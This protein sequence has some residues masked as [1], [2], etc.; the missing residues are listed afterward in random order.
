MVGEVFQKATIPARTALW[1]VG[2]MSFAT[3][4][5]A[6]NDTLLKLAAHDLSP[7]N[8]MF[9]RGISAALWS[10]PLLLFMRQAPNLRSMTNRWVLLRSVLHLGSVFCFMLAIRHLPLGD[11][12]ALGQLS[13]ALLIVGVS[14]L[15]GERIG[16]MRLVFVALA[17]FGAL[18]LAQ[19]GSG[20]ISPYV[21]LGLASAI[22]GATRDLIGQQIPPDIPVLLVV[23]TNLMFE[24]VGAGLVTTA[25][26]SWTI[27]A[28][29]G[30][31]LLAGSG[32]FLVIG[33]S[34]FFLSYRVGSIGQ[35]AP[36]YYLYPVWS[37]LSGLLVF[38]D[39]LSGTGLIGIALI[40]MSGVA[41]VLT[42]AGD[43]RQGPLPEPFPIKPD[44]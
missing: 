23:I 1:G 37:F 39:P 20:S 15:F 4:M 9:Y 7:I 27:P 26:V 6:A 12:V 31:A 25:T 35:V 18:L 41:I 21:L 11:L 40:L 2:V 16:R 8:A 19:P 17:L 30:L 43:P 34:L 22:L 36:F 44:P 33:H 10:V 28:P 42:R 13:P 24:I 3:L 14:V 32:L 29:L 5:Y 38:R